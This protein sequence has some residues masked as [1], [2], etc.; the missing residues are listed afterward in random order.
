M[1]I[2]GRR[3]K[4]KS[5]SEMRPNIGSLLNIFPE[6]YPYKHRSALPE[7]P[8]ANIWI[9]KKNEIL[10]TTL[11]RWLRFSKRSMSTFS[12]CVPF[13]LCACVYR[14]FRRAIIYI[15]NERT[16]NFQIFSFRFCPNT[17]FQLRSAALFIY[18]FSSLTFHFFGAGV[19][20]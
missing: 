3:A 10:E 12:F 2:G 15:L 11:F 1:S 17:T 9:K 4:G 6:I 5:R 20:Y 19:R 13:G 16:G 14:C 18:I 8:N 7:F